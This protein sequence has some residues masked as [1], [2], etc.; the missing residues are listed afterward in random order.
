[1]IKFTRCPKCRTL[2]ELD[3][4]EFTESGDWVQC[5][6]CDR[7]FKATSHSVEPDELSFSV[8]NLAFDDS[9][10]IKGAVEEEDVE[11]SMQII[12]KVKKQSR[13]RTSLKKE[14]KRVDETVVQ[15]DQLVEI[16]RESKGST[17]KSLLNKGGEVKDSSIQ[18]TL[19]KRSKHAERQQL[20]QQNQSS[21]SKFS[22]KT[23]ILPEEIV[24]EAAFDNI[25]ESFG[26]DIFN[27]ELIDEEQ[28][29]GKR[30]KNR[31]KNTYIN[32]HSEFSEE[33]ITIESSFSEKSL[34]EEEIE[35]NK[36]T[37]T[38]ETFNVS[39]D[40]FKTINIEGSSLL[41][42][43]I[44]LLASFILLVGLIGLFV[45][46]IHGRGTYQLIPQNSYEGLLSHF[47]I[48]TKL[49]KTQTD[50]SAIH[51][52]STKMQANSENETARVISLQLVNRSFTNQAYPDFQ[53]EFTDAKGDIIARRVIYPS[54]YLD[55]GHYGFLESR[56]TK[57][58]FLNLEF[59]PKGAV[60]YQIK[61]VQQHS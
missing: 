37:T 29:E 8:S 35:K 46:Q 32:L 14:D 27:P 12:D 49:E 34:L 48:L 24:D 20:S 61:V 18:D 15:N 41:L 17:K 26:D 58:V 19:K 16:G 57:T 43:A 59:L 53:L 2:Y 45:L 54:V 51:L 1:M 31:L 7:K 22:E 38:T 47:P 13:E 44:P 50:L 23:I 30:S 4:V 6:E 39:E 25:L 52:A 10:K 28:S 56:Q 40:G 9:M 3:G 36:V 11:A 60:G 21:K 5:G 33:E 42:N 55:Q